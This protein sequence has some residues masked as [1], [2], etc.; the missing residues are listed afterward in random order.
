MRFFFLTIFPKLVECFCG[1][2]IV[3]QAIKKGALEVVVINPRDYAEKGKVDDYAYGGSPGMVLKPE[4]IFLAY[5]E[6]LDKY[7]KPY[8]IIPQPWGKVID[9]KDLDRLSKLDSL[10]VIC[11]RYEGIDER[12]S[13][14]AD[15]ELSLG[16][17][18]LSGGELFGLVLLE[19]IARLLPGVLSDPKSIEKDSFRRWFGSPVYTRPAEFRGMKVPEVLLSGNHRMVELWELWHSIKR[20]LEKR[21]EM[22]PTDITPLEEQ[23]LRAIKEGISF[24]EWVLKR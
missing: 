9:Q 20:T 8:T 13:S 19:G 15:E 10:L 17:F 12:V 21:P 18:V 1:Y 22:I 4:P 5:E 3:F 11:G 16:N 14:L 6:I 23:M 24:E 2:G 7:G